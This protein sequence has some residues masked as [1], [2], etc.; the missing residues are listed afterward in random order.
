M[1]RPDK[2]SQP[3]QHL[4]RSGDFRRVLGFDLCPQSPISL[5]Q[6][7]REVGGGSLQGGFSF[8]FGGVTELEM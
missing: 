3:H 2:E 4:L 5:S 7:W 6:S 1:K 8:Q